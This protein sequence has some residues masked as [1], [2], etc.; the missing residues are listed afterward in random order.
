MLVGKRQTKKK[1]EPGGGLRGGQGGKR[2]DLSPWQNLRYFFN[3]GH[4][5][6]ARPYR[7]SLHKMRL[8]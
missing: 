2:D 6:W 1:G 3:F 5:V 4:I 7:I 8:L